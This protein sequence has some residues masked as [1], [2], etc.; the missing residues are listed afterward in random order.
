[1]EVQL[2]WVALFGVGEVERLGG[3]AWP[4]LLAH[5]LLLKVWRNCRLRCTWLLLNVSEFKGTTN[6]KL[7]KKNNKRHQTVCSLHFF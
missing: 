3:G 4:S 6:L 2:L 7:P 1:M 5:R